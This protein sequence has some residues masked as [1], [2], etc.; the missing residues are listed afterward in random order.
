MWEGVEAMTYPGR[1]TLQGQIPISC[2]VGL[3]LPCLPGT[4]GI[5]EAKDVVG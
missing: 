4:G 1:P 2:P 5:S 3:V